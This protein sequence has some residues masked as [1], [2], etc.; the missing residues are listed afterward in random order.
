MCM[1][2]WLVWI[3]FERKVDI[4][5]VTL[6][7]KFFNAFAKTGVIALI[8]NYISVFHQHNKKS[9]HDSLWTK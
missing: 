7:A 9:P 8:V 2:G 6:L 3:M 5:G 1:V 4:L